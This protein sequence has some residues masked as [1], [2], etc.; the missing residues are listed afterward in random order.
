M[1]RFGSRFVGTSLMAVALSLLAVGVVWASSG[2]LRIGE[3][4]ETTVPGGDDGE[5]GVDPIDDM[6]DLRRQVLELTATVQE[7]TGII[8]T[9]ESD[10]TA[11]VAR[12]E[13]AADDAG[14]IASV[15][16]EAAGD[17]AEA[18][19][20][21]GEATDKIGAL[22]AK[23]SKLNNEGIYSG[24]ITPGQLSRRLSPTDLSG[25][26][27]LNRVTGQLESDDILVS[28]FG[29]S[30]DYRFHTVLT[31]DAFRQLRCERIAK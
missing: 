16:D 8:A 24:T 15:A 22:E 9:L 27:P 30:S 18:R 26:W 12:A 28:A 14:R 4:S 13:K 6:D 17:A 21:A 1:K 23:T 20:I 25:D 2:A 19:R 10:V 29:C 5:S 7:L 3:T 11:A 31:V